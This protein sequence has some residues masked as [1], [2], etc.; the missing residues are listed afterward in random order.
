M[1]D[2]SI[3]AENILNCEL[4]EE[5]WQYGNMNI[6]NGFVSL[7]GNIFKYMDNHSY[8]LMKVIVSCFLLIHF[9]SHARLINQSTYIYHNSTYHYFDLE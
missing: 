7:Y 9:T 3:F 5:N 4:K 6:C 8:E 2:G 1:A